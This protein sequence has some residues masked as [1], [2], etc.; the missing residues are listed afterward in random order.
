MAGRGRGSH[1]RPPGAAP[2]VTTTEAPAPPLRASRAWPV[3]AVNS[4]LAVT[5]SAAV[6]A[7]VRAGIPHQLEVSTDIV[8]YP[9]FF[10]FNIERLVQQYYLLTVVFPVLALLAYLALARATVRLGMLDRSPAASFWPPEGVGPAPSGLDGHAVLNASAGLAAIGPPLAVGALFGIE[11]AIVLGGTARTSWLI[12]AGVAFAYAGC[13]VGAAGGLRRLTGK[14]ESLSTNLA[15]VNALAAPLSFLGLLSISDV[16]S[17]T[18]QS[19]GAIHHYGWLP[20]WLA[21]IGTALAL[22]WIASRLVR[23]RTARDARQVER[24]TVLLVT[25][26]VSLFILLSSLPGAMGPMDMFHE[27]ELLMGSSLFLSGSFPWRDFMPTHGVLSDSLVPSVGILLFGSSRWAAMA[28]GFTVVDPLLSIPLYLFAVRLFHRSWAFIAIVAVAIAGDFL[29]PTLAMDARFK[30]WP[31][32]LLLLG[33]AL[34]DPAWWRSVLLGAALIVQA[35]LIPET[36]YCIPA[37]GLVLILR[38]SY[39]RVPGSLVKSF[40]RTLWCAVGGTALAAIFGT[41]LLTQH[42][43]GDF[44]FYFVIFAPGHELTGGEPLSG[45]RSPIFLYAAA[46]PVIALLGAWLYLI[47]SVLRRRP[48][49]TV[50]WIMGAAGV[51]ALLY[52]PKFLER[53][54]AGHAIQVC[55]AIMPLIVVVAYRLLDFGERAL[56]SSSWSSWLRRH[57]SQRPLAVTLLVI[58]LITTPGPLVSTLQNLPQQVRGQAPTE[59]SPSLMGFNSRGMDPAVYADLKSVFHAY[60]RPG[61]WVFDFSNAPGLYYYLLQLTP[62]SRYYDVSMAMPETAQKDLISELRR[63]PPK[64]VVFTNDRFGQPG[65]DNIPNMVRHYDVSQYIL[66]H[67]RPL[68]SVDGQIIYADEAAHLPPP[69]SLHLHLSQPPVTDLLP[70]RGQVCDWGYAPNFLSISPPPPAHEMSP[71]R[72]TV[73]GVGSEGN[74]VS[75]SG[76]AQWLTLSPP[77]GRSWSDYRWLEI[78][79]RGSLQTDEWVLSDKRSI[80]QEPPITFK[81]LGGSSHIYKVYVGNCAQWHGYQAVPLYVGHSQSQAIDA[82]RLLG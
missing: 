56:E 14:T 59:P 9:I 16:T 69:E 77:S 66:D 31:L 61:D 23:A 63:H 35:A 44:L 74:D 48:L 64:L 25:G 41:Y 43:L 27:G 34:D 55:A 36:A 33:L 58:A 26:P 51:F 28:G 70:F 73:T 57:V 71:I 50:D 75:T 68:L 62:R 54:D 82:I 30:F 21:L 39:H 72:L 1:A 12:L 81:T 49:E 45:D 29:A 6:V 22:A 11:A 20:T 7:A 60:L 5:F 79:V 13:A 40:S 18:V 32:V 17:V 15:R 24:W 38:D 67:Y 76:E 37:C 65:W 80:D 19:D 4:L 42:A 3:V 10:N 78:E 2:R 47:A 53:M 46:I 52:Y 8:G